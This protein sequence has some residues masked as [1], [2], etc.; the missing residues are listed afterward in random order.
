MFAHQKEDQTWVYPELELV[1]LAIP[2]R[3]YSREHLD[4]VCES[5]I[6]LY[7]SKES[8]VGLKMTYDPGFLR[9]FNALF[10]PI[11]K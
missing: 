9:H 7:E 8:I 2:R 4:Y 6:R 3:V 1:R 10:E 5:I 11:A